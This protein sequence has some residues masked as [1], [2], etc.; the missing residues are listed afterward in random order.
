MTSSSRFSQSSCVD[1]L[2]VVVLEHEPVGLVRIEGLGRAGALDRSLAGLERCVAPEVTLLAVA[3]RE[4]AFVRD[5]D[6]RLDPVVVEAGVELE[7]ELHRPLDA[8]HFAV[9]GARGVAELH[10]ARDRHEVGEHHRPRLG[11]EGGLE[12][13][14][15]F[16]VLLFGG[17]LLGRSNREVPA[18]V[19][20]EQRGEDARRLDVRKATPVDRAVGGDQRAGFE[21][22]DD[23]VLLYRRESHTEPTEDPH[24]V[25]R[26]AVAPE[27]ELR[28][29]SRSLHRAAVEA[30]VRPAVLTPVGRPERAD[31]ACVSCVTRRARD[32]VRR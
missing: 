23:P 24:I 12:H 27:G 10:R 25:P 3:A 11:L 29:T 5:L 22:P 20:V 14:G 16:D 8:G 21:V 17:E 32:R 9:D 26:D 13:V 30:E 28:P 4:H 19:L 7:F 18:A 6:G 15:S 1:R 31:D 2:A